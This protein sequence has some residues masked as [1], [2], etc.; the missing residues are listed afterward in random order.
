MSEK[1]APEYP[2]A[3][4]EIMKTSFDMHQKGW[5]EA[6]GGNISLRLKPEFAAEIK[7]FTPLSDW[8]SLNGKVPGLAEEYFLVSGTGRYLRNIALA[9]A[10]NTGII[11]LDERGENYR[12]C[13]GYEGD[14]HPTSEL[15][16]HLLTHEVRKEVSKNVEHAVIHTHTPNLIAL[17]YH[18]KLTTDRLTEIL[19]THHVE[20]IVV[21]PEGVY[22]LPWMMAGTYEI[23]AA[24]AEA[25]RTHRMVVWEHHGIFASGRNLD[26]SF[27]LIHTAEKSAEIYKI[28]CSLG[29]IT[30]Y[31]DMDRLQAIA[32]NFGRVPNAS[33]VK[34][35]QL[36]NQDRV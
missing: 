27:G 10:K 12:I 6:N 34:A 24:T 23:G 7:T 32:A 3:I 22:M 11:Q 2:A 30:N 14:S 4:Q 31:P 21:F 33:I 35:I 9:P 28:A 19:W 13:W 18:E 25:M 29:G 36:R 15:F 8:I 20:C 17:S 26:E 5:T 1:L 16:A